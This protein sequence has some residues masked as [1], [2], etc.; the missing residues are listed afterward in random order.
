[1]S[2][3]TILF[4]VNDGVASITLNRPDAYNALTVPMYTE[5]LDALKQVSRDKTVRAMLLTGSGKGF[6]SGADLLEVQNNLESL[7]IGD[8]LRTGLNQIVTGF[9]NLEKP[10]ICALNG[11]AAGAGASLALATDIRIASEKASF[12]FAAFVNIG[13]IPDAG[14]TYFLPELVG[15]AKAFELAMLA[16]GQNR[17]G[18][19]QAQSLGLVTRITAHDD[20]MNE[21]NALANKLA[22]MPTKAIGLAK[23]AIYK[24]SERSL[25]GQ[26]ETEAQ[27]QTIASR[28]YDFQE[29]VAAFVEKREPNFKGN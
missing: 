12:V 28:S 9:R 22:N 6:C 8:Y 19:E 2:Y 25:D 11:V 29:G 26:L 17:V 21:A 20:L 15:P 16:D 1:M 23:R 7:A 10:I 4:E 27:L 24:A 13:L 18:P 5:I 3:E 14:G